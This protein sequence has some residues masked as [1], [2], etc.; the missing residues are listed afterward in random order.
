M[1]IARSADLRRGTGQ[2]EVSTVT[3]VRI[4]QVWVVLTTFESWAHVLP[5][6]IPS[7]GFLSCHGKDRSW[8]IV[9][10]SPCKLRLVG[11]LP[12]YST[13]NTRNSKQKL[14]LSVCVHVCVCAR[15]CVHVCVC[16]CVCARVCVHVCVCVCMFSVLKWTIWFRSN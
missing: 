15:V 5:L 9:Q 4:E 3:R 13:S 1:I 14:R 12:P 7:V 11:S 2:V 8:G 16:T 6:C 10:R